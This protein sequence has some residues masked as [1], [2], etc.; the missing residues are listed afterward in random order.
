VAENKVSVDITI[1]ERDALKALKKLARETDKSTSAMKNMF[2][3][4]DIAIGVTA[5]NIASDLAGK[6]IGFLKDSFF[7][8]IDAANRQEDSINSLNAALRQNGVFSLV[9]SEELREFASELQRVTKFGDEATLEQLAFAQ[10]MGASISQSKQIVKAAAD[11]SA[12]LG[13]DFN[14]AVRNITKTLGGLKGELGEAIPALGALTQEQLRSGA[15]IDLVANM[16]AGQAQAATQTFS[17]RVTQLSNSWGD[18]L[19]EV[20]S[21]VTKSPLVNTAIE[22]VAKAVRGLTNLITEDTSTEKLDELQKRYFNVAG[23]ISS[24]KNEIRAIEKEGGFFSQYQLNDKNKQLKFMEAALK[25]INAEMDSLEKKRADSVQPPVP[26]SDAEIELNNKKKASE[27]RFQEEILQLKNEYREKDRAM[28]LMDAEQ[29]AAFDLEQFELQKEIKALQEQERQIVDVQTKEQLDAIDQSFTEKKLKRQKEAADEAKKIEKTKADEIEKIEQEAYNKRLRVLQG[30]NSAANQI[31]QAAGAVNQ[32]FAKGQNKELFLIQKIA[33][34]AAAEVATA[35][36]VAQASA[37]PP[38]PNFVLAGIAAA[39]GRAQQAA[40]LKTTIDAFAGGGV[41]GGTFTG[42]SSGGDNRMAT[43]RDGEMILNAEQQENLF[44]GINNG[45]IG[46]DIVIEIDGR[47][48]ARAV[49][50]QRQQGFQV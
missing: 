35:L 26:L 29:K 8:T 5:G 22:T 4:L 3:D 7:A 37:I 12:A 17:G 32:A 2:G 39:A 19:E 21:F 43:V 9:A 24:L 28:I 48:I 45:N 14:S 40:I 47:E 11:M 23:E 33:A 15:A 41:V 42:A 18:L 16:F 25:K 49:R 20:G 46:G 27:K 6:A 44:N 13:M 50:D 30:Y 38:S 36:A 31:Q 1:E 34:L 10:S